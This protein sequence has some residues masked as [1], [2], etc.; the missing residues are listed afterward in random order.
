MHIYIILSLIIHL[1][2]PVSNKKSLQNN[3]TQK[4]ITGFPYQYFEKEVLTDEMVA[5]R[6][7]IMY[8]SI[9]ISTTVTFSVLPAVSPIVGQTSFT[10]TSTHIKEKT[11][12]LRGGDEKVRLLAIITW[13]AKE[14]NIYPPQVLQTFV[15]LGPGLINTCG[16]IGFDIVT[17]LGA[18]ASMKDMFGPVNNPGPVGGNKLLGKFKKLKQRLGNQ[19]NLGPAGAPI[20]VGLSNHDGI[21]PILNDQ[22]TLFAL[23][24]KGNNKLLPQ[25][26]KTTALNGG[27]ATPVPRPNKL[28]PPPDKQSHPGVSL[29][30]YEELEGLPTEEVA[31]TINPTYKEF[32]HKKT[33]TAGLPNRFE[34][35]KGEVPVKE[36]AEFSTNP[37]TGKIDDQSMDEAIIMYRGKDEGILIDPTRIPPEVAKTVRLDSTVS[38]SKFKTSSGEDYKF[39]DYKALVSEEISKNDIHDNRTLKESASASGAKSVLQKRRFVGLEG[40]PE[41]AEVVGHLYDLF[42]VPDEAK[43]FAKMKVLEGAK[44]LGSE[45]G[46][47]FVNDFPEENQIINNSTNDDKEL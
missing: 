43:A 5:A 3:Y 39:F 29:L 2:I 45:E 36:F 27:E 23:P 24:P 20:T 44:F 15:N 17:L 8:V 12:D 14:N 13:L 10:Q 11:L 47:F 25:S 30:N 9:M 4:I 32:I 34:Q 22:T 35:I 46:I 1:G 38:G 26:G 21:R 33:P 16:S 41:S 19:N 40:G 7:R 37:L 6:I 28:L 18:C 42:Y 31:H